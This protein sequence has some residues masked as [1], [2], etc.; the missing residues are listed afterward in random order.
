MQKRK[1]VDFNLKLAA[2]RDAQIA[3]ATKRKLWQYF[4]TCCKAAKTEKRR[5]HA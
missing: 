1:D 3:A 5:S 4:V 2:R